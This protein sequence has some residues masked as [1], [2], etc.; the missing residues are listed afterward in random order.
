MDRRARKVYLIR[1]TTNQSEMTLPTPFG[2]GFTDIPEGTIMEVWGS[3][4]KDD[5]G[6]FCEF[7][8]LD[9]DGTQ[10]FRTK[11]IGGY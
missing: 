5:G 10:A 3:S 4:I 2:P 1:R 8:L 9:K 7:R 11:R 6:D